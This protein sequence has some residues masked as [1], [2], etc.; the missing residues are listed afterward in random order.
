MAAG[1]GIACRAYCRSP[2]GNRIRKVIRGLL[3]QPPALACQT[4]WH[5]EA[6][7]CGMHGA[8]WKSFSSRGAAYPGRPMEWPG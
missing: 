1:D 5:A 6:V 8:E 4:R 3:L 7:W 2:G